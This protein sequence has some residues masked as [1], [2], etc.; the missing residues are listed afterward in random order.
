[1]APSLRM[2][3]KIMELANQLNESDRKLLE[4]YNQGIINGY[5]GEFL[6]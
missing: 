2:S 3:A 6:V 1:M 5:S 4:M